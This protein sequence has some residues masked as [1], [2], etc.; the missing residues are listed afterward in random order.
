MSVPTEI[1]YRGVTYVRADAAPDKF[2]EKARDVLP[3]LFELW[4][5]DESFDNLKSLLGGQP[6]DVVTDKL[7][8]KFTTDLAD[9]ATVLVDFGPAAERLTSDD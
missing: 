3:M 2:T 8:D 9:I 5:G 1:V 6:A 4:I 7:R